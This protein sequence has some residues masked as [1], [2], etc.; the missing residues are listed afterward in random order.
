MYLYC[1]AYC[2][3]QSIPEQASNG[4]NSSQCTGFNGVVAVMTYTWGSTQSWY[5]APS[6]ATAQVRKLEGSLDEARQKL[7]ESRELLKTN[8]NGGYWPRDS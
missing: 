2:T 3:V 8:E 5:S 4:I 6:P 1:A 7:E